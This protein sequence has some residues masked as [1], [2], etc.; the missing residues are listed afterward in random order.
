MQALLQSATRQYQQQRLTQLTLQRDSL[1]TAL[2]TINSIG[3]RSELS[4]RLDP[5]LADIHLWQQAMP[6]VLH[7]IL[8]LQIHA[9]QARPVLFSAVVGALLG[10][11]FAMLVALVFARR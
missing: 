7:P 9:A 3:E 10:A 2:G 11:L 1:Q 8:P 4:R 5:V 6:Q